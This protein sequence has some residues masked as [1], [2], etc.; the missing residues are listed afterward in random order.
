MSTSNVE[1]GRGFGAVVL[2]ALTV[3]AGSTLL[4]YRHCEQILAR[5]F[6][7][8]GQAIPPPD[9]KHRQKYGRVVVERWSQ[10]AGNAACGD[11]YGW[12]KVVDESGIVLA[13]CLD[14][15]TVSPDERWMVAVPK[16]TPADPPSRRILVFDLRAG[17]L[18]RQVD[19]PEVLKPIPRGWSPDGRHLI[20]AS[21]FDGEVWILS[22]SEK[23]ATARSLLPRSRDLQV[24]WDPEGGRVAMLVRN[25]GTGA[26]RER[27]LRLHCVSPE[28]DSSSP[29]EEVVRVGGSAGRPSTIRWEG[30]RPHV[31][32]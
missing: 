11:T 9:L 24:A 23:G 8:I 14:G 6:R 19:T 7:G 29:R 2:A 10:I 13:D 31:R 28:G 4:T 5:T 1:T 21:R 15:W 16:P 12:G 25:S 26:N 27:V 32:P 17:L 18:I 30:G 3:V 22:C 20:L